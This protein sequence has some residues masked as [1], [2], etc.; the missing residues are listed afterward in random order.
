MI[1]HHHLLI[2]IDGILKGLKNENEYNI[3]LT[4]S[5]IKLCKQKSEKKVHGNIHIPF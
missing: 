3:E 5:T 1:F 2:L 4:C